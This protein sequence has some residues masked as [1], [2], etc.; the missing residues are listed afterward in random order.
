MA[1][2]QADT[3]DWNDEDRRIDAVVGQTALV[4]PKPA[5]RL[6]GISIASFYRF[7]RDGR[8]ET[9]GHGDGS[10]VRRAHLRGLMRG[11]VPSKP[12]HHQPT[13]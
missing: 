13:R 12:H 10:A 4:R 3:D 2:F 11:G 9:V 1:A 5:A 7:V 8:I 6:L